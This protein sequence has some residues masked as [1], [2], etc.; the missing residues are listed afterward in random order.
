MKYQDFIIELLS[1][2]ESP[3]SEQLL[4]TLTK[5]LQ[6][7]FNLSHTRASLEVKKCLKS[8]YSSQDAMLDAI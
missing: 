5:A 4:K 7:E 2:D 3:I 1:S 8:L 6:D